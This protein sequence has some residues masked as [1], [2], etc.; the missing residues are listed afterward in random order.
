MGMVIPSVQVSIPVKQQQS[1]STGPSK[2]KVTSKLAA[3][4]SKTT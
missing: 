1:K 2:R 4:A 3:T